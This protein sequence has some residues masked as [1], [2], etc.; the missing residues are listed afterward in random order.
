[1]PR[2]DD[3]EDEKYQLYLQELED[4]LQEM[5]DKMEQGPTGEF[6]TGDLRDMSAGARYIFMVF[7]ILDLLLD[8]IL[9][10]HSKQLIEIKKQLNE[11]NK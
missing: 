1:M 6:D 3:I 2:Q 7:P 11:L 10:Q 4:S 9:G 5:K 8:M